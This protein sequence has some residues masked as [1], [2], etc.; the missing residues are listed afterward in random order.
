MTLM[1]KSCATVFVMFL[2]IG[3]SSIAA[4][5]F[6]HAW[7]GFET[8]FR[9]LMTEQEM[10]GAAVWFFHEG[11]PIAKS[12]HGLADIEENRPVD[13]D[14]IFHWGSVTKTLTGIAILQLRDRGLLQ[15]DD[16]VVKHLPELRRVHNPYGSMEE[17]TIR[18]V[19]THSAG[20]R[21]GTWPWGSGEPWQ[22]FEPTEWEQLVAMFPYTRIEFEPG[23]RYGYSNPAVIFLG[24]IIE[25]LTGEDYEVYVDKNVFKPLGMHRSYFDRTPYHLLGF[26]SNNYTVRD[27]KPE[28]NG[29]DFDTGITVSNS[30]LNAPITDMG[31]Y[32]AFLM[33]DPARRAEY[34][35]IL[36]RSSLEE[37][38]EP[39][40][41]MVDPVAEEVEGA[42]DSI[43][44]I[45]FV[46]ERNGRELAGHT[47]SQE[48]FQSFLYVDPKART[49]AVAAFNADG[50]E[51]DG[52][53]RPDARKVLTSVRERVFEE[54]F[55]LFA[56]KRGVRRQ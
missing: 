32:A 21:A 24:R 50:A 44:L 19:M 10:V 12:L 45:F 30:G 34:D 23:S 18:H 28:A 7:E 33:G 6:A 15:L 52:V 1:V 16:P 29:L 13:E 51:K 38:W 35:R 49:A 54:L 26:R 43:G 47:G 17:I 53:R 42:R 56:A 39:R 25:I 4:N 31:L 3:T 11:R 41:P 40:L 46:S 2:A 9:D 36:K 5:D 14:T 22:P 20:F 55:P 8:F 27:G 48:A 37:M